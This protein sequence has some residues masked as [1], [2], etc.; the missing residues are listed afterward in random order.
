[1]SKVRDISNL[2]NVIRTDASGNVSFVS[3]STTLAT[4]NTSGQLSGSSP[5][6]SSSYALNATSASYAASA[7]NATNAVTASFANAFTVANTLTATTLVVQTVSSSVIYSSGS[8]VF[9]NNIAN[10]QVFT[11][12]VNITGSLAVVTTGTEFQVTST[13][14]NLGNALTD[15]H[16]ISG[17][18]RINPNGL[19][20]TSSGNVGIGLTTPGMALD[21][22]GSVGDANGGMFR[23]IADGGGQLRMGASS[24]YSWIQA[25]SSKPL[26]INP[27]GNNIVMCLAAGSVGIGTSTPAYKFETL[28]TSVI[29]AAFGRSDYGA[30][31]VML[32]AMNGYRDVYKQAIG[33]VRTGDY[34]KGDMIFCLN[35]AANSTVVSSS[36]EKM[37]ITSAGNVGIGTSSPGTV[38]TETAIS[39]ILNVYNAGNGK[40]Y[41]RGGGGGEL[42][43]EDTGA[44]SGDKI[45]RW[46]YDGGVLSFQRI[47]DA[48]TAI[49]STPLTITSAGTVIKPNQ[50]AF[51]A[52]KSAGT[53]T[54]TSGVDTI[55]QFNTLKYDIQSNFNTS[56]YRFTAPVAGRYQF[57]ATARFDNKTNSGYMRTYFTVNG[58]GASYS[59]GHMIIGAGGASTGGFSTSYQG[60]SISAVIS[61]SAGDYVMVQG[62]HTAQTD[63]H[64]ESQFSGYLLG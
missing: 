45:A 64:P 28:G 6:L 31:N 55:L 4:L 40:I 59:Y 50:P 42:G 7:S 22:T 32:I 52:G 21:I 12:S 14:V 33:V 58:S 38:G 49:G 10:T 16:T 13:G 18:L 24:S 44:G 5:V 62:G 17:S 8:N 15:S 56:T 20:V 60:M 1:M 34:D 48:F 25:H 39:G 30:S 36:D 27:L 29:T 47:N 9:G 37:R 41:A 2:S 54:I 3:G 63:F 23:L 43:F 57:N 19:F 53:Q 51:Q 46:I 35:A 61:L 11:G 26:Y